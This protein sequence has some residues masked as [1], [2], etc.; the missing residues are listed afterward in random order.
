[1]KNKFWYI[2]ERHNPQFKQPYYVALGNISKKQA[3]AYESSIYGD[4]TV[5][6]F[7]S[8]ERYREEIKRLKNARFNVQQAAL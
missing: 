6:S 2:K 7:D 3:K 5:F 4:N 1:M 8:E